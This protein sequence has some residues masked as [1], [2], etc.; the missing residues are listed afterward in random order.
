MFH[1]GDVD[2]LW[3]ISQ[4]A[5]NPQI[6]GNKFQFEDLVRRNLI[7]IIRA[8]ERVMKIRYADDTDIEPL[9]P[10]ASRSICEAVGERLQQAL[11]PDSQMSPHLQ[12]L[13]DEL[14]RREEAEGLTSHQ[15]Y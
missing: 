9:D 1:S 5:K 14:R 6:T 13:V 2:N 7:V 12:Y 15:K 3:I 8:R 10:R 11:R 4:I